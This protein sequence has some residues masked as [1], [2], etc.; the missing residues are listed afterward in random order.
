MAK[1]NCDSRQTPLEDTRGSHD[2]SRLIETSVKR[3]ERCLLKVCTDILIVLRFYNKEGAGRA[4]YGP[5]L[6]CDHMTQ[7]LPF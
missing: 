4:I 6:V 1:I 5:T 2:A 3:I 7:R